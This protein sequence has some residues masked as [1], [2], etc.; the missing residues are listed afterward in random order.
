M[1]RS[2][3]V[4]PE[5]PV[6][7]VISRYPATR[8]VFHRLGMDTCCSSR[9]PIRRAAAQAGVPVEQVMTE[10]ARYLAQPTAPDPA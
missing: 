3:P 8:E 10:L 4:S 7:D 2:E 6:A 1:T 5:T 9:L